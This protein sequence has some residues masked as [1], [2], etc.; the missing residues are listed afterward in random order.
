[1]INIEKLNNIKKENRP[2]WVNG[3]NKGGVITW[4]DDE[5]K[6]ADWI[7]AFDVLSAIRSDAIERIVAATNENTELLEKKY[8]Q[9]ERRTFVTQEAEAKA[10]KLA[11]DASSALPP[12]PKLEIIASR[13]GV[14]VAQVVTKVLARASAIDAHEIAYENLKAQIKTETDYK[15][16]Q[17]IN[18]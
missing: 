1:M 4:H 9:V 13:R 15:I 8:P 14:T 3:T 12:T 5:Q 2:L 16:I 10:Y 11:V 17:N 18:L 7:D 6:I